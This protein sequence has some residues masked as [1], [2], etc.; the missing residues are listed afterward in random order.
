MKDTGL[1]DKGGEQFNMAEWHS[2][3]RGNNKQVICEE[4]GEMPTICLE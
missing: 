2:E 3:E 1:T 4:K